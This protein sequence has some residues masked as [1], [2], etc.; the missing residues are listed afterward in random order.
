M[1]FVRLGRVG[2]R[3]KCSLLLRVWRGGVGEHKRTQQGGRV[4]TGGEEDG[5]S[6]AGSCTRNTNVL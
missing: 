3:V 4:C 5:N 2:L 1:C 6:S